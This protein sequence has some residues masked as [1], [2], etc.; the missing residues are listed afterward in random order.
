MSLYHGKLKLT[1]GAQEQLG[2]ILENDYTI[3]D[4]VFRIQVSGKGCD[5]FTYKLGFTEIQDNDVIFQE[6]N[7]K[8]HLDPFSSYYIQDAQIDYIFNLRNDQDGFKLTNFQE[9]L[10]KGK[11]F[12]DS[13]LTPENPLD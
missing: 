5:G 6:N 4:K 8:I 3:K 2:L 9:H 12:K 13:S 11:F 1:Q 10:F 7:I